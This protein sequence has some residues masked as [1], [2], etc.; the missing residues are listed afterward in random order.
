MSREEDLARAKKAMAKVRDVS[1]G[2]LER[3]RVNLRRTELTA[4]DHIKSLL[5]VNDMLMYRILRL[6]EKVEELLK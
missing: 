4:E 6:E 3:R 2:C 1:G 5:L